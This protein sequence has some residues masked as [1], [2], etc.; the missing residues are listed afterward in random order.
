MDAW[1]HDETSA[2]TVQYLPKPDQLIR[3]GSVFCELFNHLKAW[4]E[5]PDTMLIDLSAIDASDAVRSMRDPQMIAG[6]AMRK[7]QALHL[8]ALP[9]VPTKADVALTLID[10]V[11]RALLEAP[12][13]HLTRQLDSVDWDH[14]WKVLDAGML[15][16]TAPS[17]DAH[18]FTKLIRRMLA[19]RPTLIELIEAGNSPLV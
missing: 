17:F 7:L 8:I 15:L 3:L 14:E 16:R 9:G 1:D 5:V 10:S 11:L 13:S 4:F 19:V 18:E 2:A 12:K 6:F